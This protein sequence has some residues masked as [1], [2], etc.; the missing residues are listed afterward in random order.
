MRD[1]CTCKA[2]RRRPVFARLKVREALDGNRHVGI[3]CHAHWSHVQK[4][5]WNEGAGHRERDSEGAKSAFEIRHD[6]KQGRT[7]AVAIPSTS[8]SS[9]SAASRACPVPRY[10]SSAY[11]SRSGAVGMPS[12]S[13]VGIASGPGG[14]M[15]S[16]LPPRA[17]GCVSAGQRPWLPAL[18]KYCPQPVPPLR[19]SF[20]LWSLDLFRCESA[21]LHTHWVFVV[22]G[23]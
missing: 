18:S 20:D 12:V 5:S 4:Q 17:A 13:A 14:S 7:Q 21:I 1:R 9:S 8:G 2:K 6:R 10:R 22:T 15:T 16:R 11:T 3:V 19:L 23:Q